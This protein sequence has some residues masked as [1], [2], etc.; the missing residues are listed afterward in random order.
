ME[1]GSISRGGSRALV[2]LPAGITGKSSRARSL[3]VDGFTVVD[4]RSDRSEP[5]YEARFTVDTI[6]FVLEGEKRVV[7]GSTTLR[8]E[9]GDAF[10]LRRGRHAMS[11]IP[12]EGGDY[13]CALVFL[14]PAVVA[15]FVESR[16]RPTAALWMMP[17]VALRRLVVPPLARALIDGLPSLFDDPAA[18]DA[19][20]VR[21]KLMELLLYLDL[22][23]ENAGFAGDLAP[24][25]RALGGDLRAL[26]GERY[27]EPL[28]LADF[29]RLSGRSLSAFKRDFTAVFNEP[30]GRWLRRE[31]LEKARFL[32]ESGW[33]NV[34]EVCY[35]VGFG[36]LSHFIQAFKAAHGVTP[37]QM[38]RNR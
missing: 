19:T 16:R 25:A 24:G 22:A 8:L 29:A 38:S 9:T 11:E 12:R 13:A 7:S 26:M 27:L 15:E 28:D 14:A 5:F 33:G 17:G 6:G 30:P 37:K 20:V 36:G 21:V 1:N 10:L 23:P 32:L 35:A 4:Y 2:T 34:T 3:S 31:R 18:R